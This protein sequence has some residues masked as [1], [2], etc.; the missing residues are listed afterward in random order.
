MKGKEVMAFEKRKPNINR[1]GSGWVKTN[2][3][4]GKKSIGFTITLS[5][6]LEDCAHG[7]DKESGE[8]VV[9]LTAF[10][11]DNKTKE[12]SPDFVIYRNTVRDET[13]TETPVAAAV[14]ADDFPL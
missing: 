6:L 10:K 7:L 9:Y 11:V 14:A 13:K 12:N 4:N 2:E 1:A 3:T 8:K 5:K